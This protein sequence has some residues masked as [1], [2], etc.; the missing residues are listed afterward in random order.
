[1][2]NFFRRGGRA[3]WAL[4]GAVLLL[5][6]GSSA[7]FART[8]LVRHERDV[9]RMV[10]NDNLQLLDEVRKSSGAL[11]D[12]L[13][14]V[15]SSSA[16]DAIPR[17]RPYIVVSIEDHRLWYKQGD[18]VLFTTQVATGSGKVLDG[19]GPDS[20]WK[21]ETPRGRLVVQSKEEDP[22]W[23]PPDWHFIEQ[24]RKRG[25]GI[26]RLNRGQTLAARDG[27]MLSVQGTDIVR[28]YH[29]G[30]VVPIEP[31]VEGHEIVVGGNLVIPPYGTNQ[32]KYKGVLG[33]HRLNLGDGYALHGTDQPQSIGHSVSHG[34]VRLRNEDIETLYQMVSVGTPVFIY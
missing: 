1:M 2:L 3:A 13:A 25:L 34:C 5:M 19:T 18:T 28:T 20:H 33:T 32:R 12:S 31:G 11:D 26:V 10:F 24:A 15:S 8:A 16:S 27:S 6:V 23:I 22:A 17:D 21:F 14:H 30:R 9:N 7:L 4:I 29:D